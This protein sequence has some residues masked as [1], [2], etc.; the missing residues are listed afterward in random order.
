MPSN[1]KHPT[2]PLR[3]SIERARKLYETYDRGGFKRAGAADAWG[4]SVKSY[5]P[6]AHMAALGYYSLVEGYNTYSLTD[7]AFLLLTSEEGEPERSRALREA[8][9]APAVFRELHET[10][11]NGADE[12]NLRGHLIREL[13]FTQGGAS[14]CAKVWNETREFAQLSS[15]TLPATQSPARTPE[16]IEPIEQKRQPTAVVAAPGPFS[17]EIESGKYVVFPR[18]LSSAQWDMV[19]T[20]LQSWRANNTVDEDEEQRQL[21]GKGETSEGQ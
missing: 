14:T 1:P 4:Y 17:M 18:N 6:R 5:S 12:N 10:F 8:A 21:P 19:A 3:D 13:K 20:M 7:R 11:P 16:V 2:I 9:L 15:E